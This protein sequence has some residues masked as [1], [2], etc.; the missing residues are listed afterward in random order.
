MDTL[1]P[2]LEGLEHFQLIGCPKV[3]EKGIWAVIS[4]NTRGLLTLGLEALSP[5]FVKFIHCFAWNLTHFDYREHGNFRGT[6]HIQ[7][8][9]PTTSQYHRNC[10]L[11]CWRTWLVRVSCALAKSLSSGSIPVILYWVLSWPTHNQRVMAPSCAKPRELFDAHI[12]P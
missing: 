8:L 12:S 1:S 7:Q 5:R 6:M 9:S 4:K 11:H 3:T 2:Y 10:T